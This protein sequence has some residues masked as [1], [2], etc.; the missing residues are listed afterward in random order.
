LWGAV[1]ISLSLA[2][3]TVIAALP[4]PYVSSSRSNPAVVLIH[5]ALDAQGG[6]QR[7]RALKALSWQASGY[8]YTLDQ[9]ADMSGLAPTG[10]DEVEQVHDL[11][12]HRYRSRNAVLQPGSESATVTIMA[13]QAVA[14]VASNGRQMPGTRGQQQLIEEFWALSPERLL[15]SALDAGDAHI[16]PDAA[17]GGMLQHVVAFTLDGAPVR[18]Y[19]DPASRLPTAWEY[20]G[21][22][23]QSGTA[24]LLGD[25]VL[26]MRYS[27]WSLTAEGIHFPLQWNV[28][29]DG[30]PDH[31]LRLHDLQL[32]PRLNES[33]LTISP[34]VREAF[35]RQPPAATAGA[36][37]LASIQVP[38]REIAP[39]VLWSGDLSGTP[40]VLLIHQDGGV[41][42]VD[43]PLSSAYS[44][45]IITEAR[46]RFPGA[47][48]KAVVSISGRW[49][50]VA[51]LREYVAEG[52]PI[53]ALAAN[54]PLLERVLATPHTHTPDRLT[55]QPV[56]P[57]FHWL[58]GSETGAVLLGIGENRLHLCPI[59][60]VS[61]ADRM[62]VYLPVYRLLY[63]SV[64][65]AAGPLGG[66][67]LE[68][69]SEIANM[70]T[71]Y[72]LE[73]DQLLLDDGVIRSWKDATGALSNTATQKEY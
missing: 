69:W 17:L 56:K 31:M 6:E 14:H 34:D 45:Q 23:A 22:L 26:R 33:E 60:G 52:I 67:D 8:H 71:H 70:V 19:F 64:A 40:G 11:A 43:A 55:R 57:L 66:H 58:T 51:G 30:Q 27:S 35:E 15:L 68:V 50:A 5:E 62:M 73:V 39:G 72:A 10:F 36:A 29:V 48:I 16:A 47:P 7:F 38:F 61:T 44:K 18:L 32:N 20:T 2:K 13:G 24:A 21:P 1:T 42:V 41:I 46:R 37:L 28:E 63:A 53:Y 54:R 4:S 49:A 9:S 12:G 25:A 59:R 65:E 3:P